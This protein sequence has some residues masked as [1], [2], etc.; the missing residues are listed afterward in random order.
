MRALMVGEAVLVTPDAKKLGL[1]MHCIAGLLYVISAASGE[2]VNDTAPRRV[3]TG[4]SI[5]TTLQIYG[6][7][8]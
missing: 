4:A 8:R 5:F 6:M 3:W 7:M 2:L 1:H